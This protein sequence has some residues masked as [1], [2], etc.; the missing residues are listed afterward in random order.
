[1]FPK[2]VEYFLVYSCQVFFYLLRPHRFCPARRVPR[3]SVTSYPT[4]VINEVA[5]RP[6]TTPLQVMEHLN[7]PGHKLFTAS[8]GG[9]IPNNTDLFA[10]I[11]D[12]E[13]VYAATEMVAG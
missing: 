12:G 2:G 4:L 13:K 5:V 10:I 11:Q 8:G 3:R 6:G 1:M 9:E 7:L